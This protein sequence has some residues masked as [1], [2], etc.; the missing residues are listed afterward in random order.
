M[1]HDRYEGRPVQALQ[2]MLRTVASVVP[3]QLT[4]APDGCYSR[5]TCEAVRCFQRRWG[6][7]PT[8]TADEQT[9]ECLAAEYERVRVEVCPAAPVQITLNPGEVLFS[10]CR[11]HK[12]ALVQLMLGTMAALVR[13]I[14]APEMTGLFD[15]RTVRAVTAFQLT[16]GLR[17]AG[18]VDKQTWKALALQFAAAS[19][20][21]GREEQA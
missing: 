3:G 19:D 5:R 7:P 18:A 14:P 4:A 10:G 13:E 16:A 1:K 17:P 15:D 12:V 21:L 8:G 20:A 2:T 11:S 6:L 9:W